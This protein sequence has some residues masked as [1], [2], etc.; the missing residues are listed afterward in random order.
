[1]SKQYNKIEKRRRRQRY[2][3]R[4]KLAAKLAR[5]TKGTSKPLPAAAVA[6]AAPAPAE[7]VAPAPEPLAS[8]APSPA[9]EPAPV[10]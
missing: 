3:K 1:M 8:P 5:L 6:P 4:K 10:A 2:L 9:A 7:A